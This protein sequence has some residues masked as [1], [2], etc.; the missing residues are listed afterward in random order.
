MLTLDHIG[1]D[2]HVLRRIGQEIR[3]GGSAFYSKLIR[4]GF[5]PG[6]RVL[7]YNCNIATFRSPD[8]RCPH[9]R[10]CFGDTP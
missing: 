8:H 4:Q 9:R 1:Q 6:F 5:P 2:A 10:G 7:C 3:T